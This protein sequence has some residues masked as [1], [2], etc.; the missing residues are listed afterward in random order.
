MGKRFP[1]R[2]IERRTGRGEN[3]KK[4]VILHHIYTYDPQM[5][6]LHFFSNKIPWLLFK[7]G[8]SFFCLLSSV[9]CGFPTPWHPHLLKWIYQ[10]F[11]KDSLQDQLRREYQF[12]SQDQLHC[13]EDQFHLQDRLRREDQSLLVDHR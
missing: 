13:R 5:K 11:S 1:A 4:C 2:F 3:E 9:L 8:D 10:F 7:P 12:H 6:V